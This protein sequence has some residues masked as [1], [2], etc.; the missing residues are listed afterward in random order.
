MSE[1]I[2][3]ACILNPCCQKKRHVFMICLK[4]I[5]EA[6]N[7]KRRHPTFS[8]FDEETNSLKGCWPV[9]QSTTLGP[10]N[11]PLKNV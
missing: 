6:M 5:D 2:F 7:N 10:Q 3:S 4:N 11:K 1:D 8:V 9:N